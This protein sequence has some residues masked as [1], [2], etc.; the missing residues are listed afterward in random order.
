MPAGTGGRTRVE[1]LAP[2]GIEPEQCDLRRRAGRNRVLDPLQHVPDAQLGI[3]RR[4]H[5]GLRFWQR[6]PRVP[7]HRGYASLH[8]ATGPVAMCSP[9]GGISANVVQPQIPVG[10]AKARQ[11]E[12]DCRR[13]PSPP[14]VVFDE[15]AGN[16]CVDHVLDGVG[17]RRYALP[18]GLGIWPHPR[19]ERV[20]IRRK[21]GVAKRIAAHE[22]VRPPPGRVRC[23]AFRSTMPE[24]LHAG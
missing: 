12:G 15:V 6:K 4:P 21:V 19:A 14:H 5:R 13:A 3:T 22:A 23:R 2:I 7:Q 16:V 18:T 20:P 11:R 24:S 9:G 10:G 1:R 17:K 8:L